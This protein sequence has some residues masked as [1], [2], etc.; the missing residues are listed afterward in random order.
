MGKARSEAIKHNMGK[1]T[2]ETILLALLDDEESAAYK[3]MEQVKTCGDSLAQMRAALDDSL[4]NLDITRGE[5]DT[6][7]ATG[8]MEMDQLSARVFKAYISA[9][10][11]MGASTARARL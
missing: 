2:P 6:A 4:Y 9:A 5:G 8:D 3:A 1:I 11:L 10:R 7:G